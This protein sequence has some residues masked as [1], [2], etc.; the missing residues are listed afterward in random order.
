MSTE[1]TIAAANNGRP[2]SALQAGVVRRSRT[3]N[4]RCAGIACAAGV[5]VDGTDCA[6]HCAREGRVGRSN[7]HSCGAEAR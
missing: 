3:T 6:V 5:R 4:T 7:R 2:L 1:H